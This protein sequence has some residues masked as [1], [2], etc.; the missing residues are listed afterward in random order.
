MIFSFHIV[1]FLSLIVDIRKKARYSDEVPYYPLRATESIF[2]L[3]ALFF[4]PLLCRGFFLRIHLCGASQT[5][6]QSPKPVQTE[7]FFC[8]VF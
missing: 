3:I 1:D 4:I 8:A 7:V 6:L 5:L 2:R